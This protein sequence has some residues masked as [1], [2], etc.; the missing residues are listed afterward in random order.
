MF[1]LDEID[2]FISS[3]LDYSQK[4]VRS[5]LKG[6]IKI[7]ESKEAAQKEATRKYDKLLDLIRSELKEH[8]KDVRFSGRLTDSLCC[9]VA[10]EED[11]DPNMERI[12]KAL[13]Q[14]VSSQKRVLEI[15]PSHP[16]LNSMQRIFDREQ[17]ASVLKDYIALIYDQ[18]L[19]LEGSKPK[20]PAL[21]ARLMTRLMAEHAEKI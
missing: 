4:P 10:G 17:S 1:L 21:H 3:E 9:L 5:V 2:D 20:D 18:A 19:I 12:L 7:D 8:V 13:G 16:L 11:M 15:N 14:N 6:D